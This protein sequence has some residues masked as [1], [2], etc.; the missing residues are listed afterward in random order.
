MPMK[1]IQE[2]FREADIDE[3]VGSYIFAHPLSFDPSDEIADDL[4]VADA[5]SRYEHCVRG[6]V[7]RIRNVETV[8]DMDGCKWVFFVHHGP[9][10]DGDDIYVVLAKQDDVLD[11]SRPLIPYGYDFSPIAETAGIPVADTY[12]TL[13]NMH[14][15]LLDYMFEA[16]FFGYGQ[17]GLQDALDRL[18]ESIAHSKEHPEDLRPID[19]L[20]ERIGYEPEVRDPVEE[21]AWRDWLH[22][23]SGYCTAAT[24]VERA[25][26]ARLIRLER[27]TQAAPGWAHG[28]HGDLSVH[29]RLYGDGAYAE[30]RHRDGEMFFACDVLDGNGEP[31]GHAC[32]LSIGDAGDAC[33]AIQRTGRR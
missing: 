7:E 31:I 23:E 25:K 3:L 30:I 16:S 26:V 29:C 27:A 18:D 28:K 32:E 24:D 13:R 19:E 14:S 20:W 15:V 2:H 22:A 12:L 33:D 10:N 11:A 6:L 8:P 9:E 5:Y 1:T 21:A 17:E 4:T